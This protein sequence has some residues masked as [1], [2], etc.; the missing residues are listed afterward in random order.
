M[1]RDSAC[2]FQKHHTA[3]LDIV[4]F[5]RLKEEGGHNAN[6]LVVDDEAGLMEL[7]QFNALEF[8]PWGAHAD[9]PDRADRVV[10]DL[11][12]GP[13]VPFAEVKRSAK[14]VRDL[15]EQ[16]G[17]QSFLRTT[18]GK[19]LHVVVPLNPANN[20]SLV[21]KFAKG[22]AEALA[23]SDPDR[24]LATATLKLR[25]RQDLRGLPAQRTR[26]DG[27]GVL[28][29]TGATGRAG[30]GAAGVV[31]AGGVEAGDAFDLEA[32]VARLK[33]QRKDPWAGIGTVKQDLGPGLEA[34][35]G[36]TYPLQ[37]SPPQRGI[38]LSVEETRGLTP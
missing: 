9:D 32:T 8:H 25:A 7:V 37:H 35:P 33:K 24:Y 6:Y 17:L 11:D 28:F 1:A 12:P 10:F 36:H 23:G 18:G 13:D 2:F 22:F 30:R 20:W 21:K 3:G 26:R 14:H 4:R 19:G 15:L 38:L 29:V 16:L 5:V 31:G 27:R 34:R